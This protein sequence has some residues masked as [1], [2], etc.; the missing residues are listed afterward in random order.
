MNRLPFAALV[1]VSTLI[2]ATNVAADSWQTGTYVYDKAGQITAIGTDS[3]A[4][5]LAGRLMSGTA[6]AGRKQEYTFDDFGNILTIITDGITSLRHDLAANPAT[7]RLDRSGSYNVFGSYDDRGNMISYIG[8]ETFTYDALNVMRTSSSSDG[9]ESFHVYDVDDE[10][11]GSITVNGPAAGSATWTMRDLSGKVLRSIHE[12]P[13]G[14][15]EWEKDYIY[16]GAQLLSAAVPTRHQ[17]LQY[18]LDHL[19]TPRLVTANG[20]VEVARFTYYPFGKDV[21][22]QPLTDTGDLK[23]TGHERDTTTLDYMHAR[24]YN[25]VTGR[26]LS[27]DPMLG[28]P[29]AP[30]TWNRYSYVQNNPVNY[31][32]PTGM[33]DCPPDRACITVTAMDPG[34]SMSMN[35]FLSGNSNTSQLDSFGRYALAFARSMSGFN[36]GKGAYSYGLGLYRSYE[37]TARRRG[38]RGPAEQALAEQEARHLAELQAFTGRCLAKPGCREKLADALMRAHDMIPPHQRIE[39]SQ[40]AAGRLVTGIAVNYLLSRVNVAAG[41]L[42]AF[43]AG[44]GDVRHH[45]HGADPAAVETLIRII[46][47]VGT[48][49]D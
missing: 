40:V 24:Y 38:D 8:S 1:I 6:G 36:Y 35:G 21:P 26:F 46:R 23:F 25:P 22:N 42:L 11:V 29:T 45:M 5:D 31:V 47:A 13:D 14:T 2:V 20:G 19:G 9:I 32:D 10:R 7:N 41:P 15:L 28:A 30:Q 12:C 16:R 27:V 33:F 48:G 18:H 34:P 43:T 49:G 39:M 4:Y 17:V 3:F 44:H 37:Y